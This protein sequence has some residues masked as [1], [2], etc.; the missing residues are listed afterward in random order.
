[1]NLQHERGINMEKVVTL[2]VFFLFASGFLCIQRDSNA[3]DNKALDETTKEVIYAISK[4][5]EI[6]EGI[7]IRIKSSLRK[8]GKNLILENTRGTREIAAYQKV[9]PSAVFI[10]TETGFGSGSIIDGRGQ[11]ITNW[12]VIESNCFNLS[13]LPVVTVFPF[14]FDPASININLKSCCQ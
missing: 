3:I 8:V 11:V 9:A 1:M 12:H 6:K 13:H 5:A 4:G 7:K 14:C 10:L 2:T